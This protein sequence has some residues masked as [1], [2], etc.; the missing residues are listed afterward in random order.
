MK[1]TKS[2]QNALVM[3]YSVFF[4]IAIIAIFASILVYLATAVNTLDNKLVNKFPAK[5]EFSGNYLNGDFEISNLPKDTLW[6]DII[7]DENL[8]YSK[9]KRQIQN[10]SFEIEEI[11]NI[12]NISNY[13]V[14][15]YKHNI[16]VYWH[17]T[18]LN[19]NLTILIYRKIESGYKIGFD[20]P[21]EL[22]G[23]EYENEL[24][25]HGYVL[26][27][28]LVFI[29]LAIII[30]FSVIT[31]SIIIKPIMKLNA[32]LMAI[33]QGELS[34][35]IEYNGYTELSELTDSF[36]HM[37]ERLEYV[38]KEAKVLAESK[39]ELLMNISHDLRTPATIVQGYSQALIDGVVPSD[40][41]EKYYNFINT[42]STMITNRLKQLFNYVK[43]DVTEF[44]LSLKAVNFTEFIRRL[45]ISYLPD[46]ESKG[47]DISLDLID[48]KIMIEIDSIEMER[49]LGNLIENAVKYN[50]EKITIDISLNKE[51]DDILLSIADNGIGINKS[52]VSTIFNPFIRGD[53]SRSTSG[54]GLGLAIS[55]QIIEQHNGSINLLH[56][57]DG[58]EFAI[59]LKMK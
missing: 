54:T 3:R 49:A 40:Q 58:V 33:K 48:E 51:N 52:D 56:L 38:E 30:F 22:K 31:H 10:S 59:K 24:N 57:E 46:I 53:K 6:F 21:D 13:D 43:V 2:L 35:R 29:V 4:V 17:K 36:N 42:K 1:W 19:E 16:D 18:N 45:T 20:V 12:I 34:T 11:N 39:K 41:K 5:I 28:V 37:T 44:D 14:T 23:T 50:S 15:T 9:G 55:K 26:M 7:I 47:H 27:L 32:G 25:K 8:V